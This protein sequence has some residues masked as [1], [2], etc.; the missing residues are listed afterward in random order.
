LGFIKKLKLDL[1][2][3][4]AREATRRAL[5]AYPHLANSKTEALTLGTLWDGDVVIFELYIPA[6]R[7]QDAIVL[8]TTRV[9]SYSG[10]ILGVEV[11]ETAWKRLA[12]Q[13]VQPDRREDA[14]P[15]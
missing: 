2:Q 5:S 9:D 4:A 14:A 13:S 10:R 3:A 15:G 8:T 11:H 7:P 12:Q 1:L 6:E